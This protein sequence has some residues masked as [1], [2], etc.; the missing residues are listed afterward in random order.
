[1]PPWV[2]NHCPAVVSCNNIVTGRAVNEPS[3]SN[4]GPW[5]IRSSLTRPINEQARA[6]FF[7]SFCYRSEPEQPIAHLGWAPE[8]G[9]IHNYIYIYIIYMTCQVSTCC[10]NTADTEVKGREGMWEVFIAFWMVSESISFQCG[11]DT[12]TPKPNQRFP[13]RPSTR[14]N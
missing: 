8:L 11:I 2:L 9:I 10:A 1:M 6:S 5:W 12:R 13:R 4:H 14:S 3:H 7:G